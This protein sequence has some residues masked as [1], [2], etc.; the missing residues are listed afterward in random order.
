MPLK[1]LQNQCLYRITRAYK[2][3][4]RAVIK[5][6]AAVPLLDIYIEVTAMQ[7]VT[8]VQDHLVEKKIYQTLKYIK[9]TRAI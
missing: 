7:R 8:T 3:T 1:K 4:P 5:C 9:K 2:K 6:K